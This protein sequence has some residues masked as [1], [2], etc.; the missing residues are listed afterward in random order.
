MK[1]WDIVDNKRAE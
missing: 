1:A